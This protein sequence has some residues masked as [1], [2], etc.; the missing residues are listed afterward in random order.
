VE[1]SCIRDPTASYQGLVRVGCAPNSKARGSA[2]PVLAWCT[3]PAGCPSSRLRQRN[4]E[5]GLLNNLPDS[6]PSEDVGTDASSVCERTK[7]G[8]DRWAMFPSYR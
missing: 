2:A 6:D 1:T 4:G 5:D 8:A 3:R 7:A